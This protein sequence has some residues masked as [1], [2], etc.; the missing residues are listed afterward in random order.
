MVIRF[1][2]RLKWFGSCAD[3]RR[4][5]C[6][7]AADRPWLAHLQV[8]SRQNGRMFFSLLEKEK[9]REIRSAEGRSNVF[10]Y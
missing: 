10:I 2:C 6:A 5:G 7:E 9:L 4:S 8:A 1:P 3:M